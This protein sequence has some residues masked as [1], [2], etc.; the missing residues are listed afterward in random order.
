MKEPTRI[1]RAMLL[2]QVYSGAIAS[3]ICPPLLLGLLGNYLHTRLD[4]NRGWMAVLI[5]LGMVIGFSSAISY[6]KKSSKITV[7]RSQTERETPYRIH[8]NDKNDKSS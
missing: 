1:Y 8:R 4:C 5:L 3:L 7:W 6:L 2:F